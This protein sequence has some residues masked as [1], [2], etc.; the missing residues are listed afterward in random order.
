V[1]DSRHRILPKGVPRLE[2]QAGVD[3]RRYDARKLKQLLDVVR[4]EWR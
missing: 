3:K 1:K 2:E 4:A